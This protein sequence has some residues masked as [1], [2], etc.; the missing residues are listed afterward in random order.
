[1]KT[2]IKNSMVLRIY[3]RTSKLFLTACML[4]SITAGWCLGS[5]TTSAFSQ[6][7]TQKNNSILVHEVAIGGEMLPTIVLSEFLVTAKK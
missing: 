1:M 7:N 6:S 5:L 3:R 2:Q 4:A